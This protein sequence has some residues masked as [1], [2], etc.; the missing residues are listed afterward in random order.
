MKKIIFGLTIALFSFANVSADIGVNVG[1]SGQMGLFA[2]TATET[3]IGTHETTTGGDEKNTESEILGLSYASIFIEKTLGDRFTVGVDYVPQALGTETDE[4]VRMDNL[5]VATNGTS[6]AQKVQV[7]FENLM[8]MYVGL[9]ITENAYVK[10]GVVTVDIVTNESLGTGS[11]YPNTDSSGAMFGMGYD[12]DMGP[13]FFRMEGTYINLDK[14]TVKSNTGVNE[15]S[16]DQL[17]GIT[18]KISVGKSF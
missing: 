14:A 8:T 11:A 2:A 13:V 6:S 7:D 5:I 9:N 18:A 17:D 4:S 1:V 10:A 16:M 12:L 15:I 3:D